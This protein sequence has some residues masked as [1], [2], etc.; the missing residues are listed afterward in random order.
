MR[1]Q[2]G[3]WRMERGQRCPLDG[4][5]MGL[6]PSNTYLEPASP[7]PCQRNQQDKQTSIPWTNSVFVM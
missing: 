5:C 6:S 1:M 4:H 7:L 3:S 2:D